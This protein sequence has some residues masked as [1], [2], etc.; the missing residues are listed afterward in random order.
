MI[1]IYRR[2]MSKKKERRGLTNI[3][4]SFFNFIFIYLFIY[5]FLFF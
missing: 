2:Y 4:I 1:D 3:E 5:L